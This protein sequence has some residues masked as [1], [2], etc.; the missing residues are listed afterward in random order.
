MV[1]YR[2]I[3]DADAEDEMWVFE[4][5]VTLTFICD[6]GATFNTAYLNGERWVVSRGEIASRYL[7]G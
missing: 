2:V 4:L 7:Q 1:P 5:L 6:L 3:F